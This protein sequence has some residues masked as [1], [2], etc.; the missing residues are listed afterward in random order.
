MWSPEGVAK[1]GCSLLGAWSS[2]GF[3]ARG[4]LRE[5][6]QRVWSPR[7]LASRGCSLL[8]AWSSEGVVASVARGLLREWPSEGV[9]S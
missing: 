1:R 2:E 6:P 7:V 5:W 9:V 4:L 8:G 3:V